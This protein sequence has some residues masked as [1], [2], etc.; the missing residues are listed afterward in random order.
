MSGKYQPKIDAAATDSGRG[1]VAGALMEG[2][3]TGPIPSGS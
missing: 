3:A 2:L 1:P